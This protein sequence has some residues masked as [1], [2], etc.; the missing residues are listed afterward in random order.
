MEQKGAAS[1]AC[2]PQ[3]WLNSVNRKNKA[4]LIEWMRSS[5]V[6]LVQENGQR[7][8]GGP[9]P[10]WVGETPPHGSEIFIGN[11]PQEIYEDTLIPLFQSV[12][13]LYEFR[14]M[15][16]FSGL[17]RGFAYA[18][19]FSKRIA[20]QA[21][22]QIGSHEIQGVKIFVC[23]STEKCEL[24]LDGLPL[25]MEQAA[26]E[27]L[28][29]EMT[30]GVDLVSLYASPFTDLKNMAVVKYNSHREAA[31]AKK[32]LCEGT[33][34]LYGCIFTVDW[35]QQSIRLKM[36]SGTLAK[37]NS[38]LPLISN[39]LL[40]LEKLAPTATQCLQLLC[41]KLMFGQPVYQIKFLRYGNCGWLR[42]WYFVLI[43]NHGVPFTGYSWLVGD[44]LIPT[45]KYQQAKEMVASIIIKEFACVG[46]QPPLRST[47]C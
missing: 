28:L 8:Y 20:D 46:D 45:E 47:L 12:G 44:K 14:L 40:I 24:M 17:N 32:S 29:G 23:R 1:A 7:K 36:Q 6:S 22:A 35:L 11:I 15:M 43:P 18:R 30:P 31:L 16:T 27:D 34:T 39:K 13:K 2:E 21:I 41:E 42:F 5:N 9:P 3:I 38:L 33:R 10:G 19:Y 25:L 37:P 4:G 26:L